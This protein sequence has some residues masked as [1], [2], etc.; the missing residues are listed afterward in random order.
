MT[1]YRLYC[2]DGDGEYTKER[3]IGATDDSDAIAQVEIMQV[4]FQCELW[5]RARF[6]VALSPHS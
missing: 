5:E 6:I 2:L 3:L 4:Q 1:E